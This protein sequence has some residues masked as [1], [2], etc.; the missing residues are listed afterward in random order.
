[1]AAHLALV[2]RDKLKLCSVPWGARATLLNG[3][4]TKRQMA[5]RPAGS[6]HRAPLTKG[7]PPAV[8]ASVL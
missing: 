5:M 3:R 1:M 6:S 4:L 8:T 2:V 7:F